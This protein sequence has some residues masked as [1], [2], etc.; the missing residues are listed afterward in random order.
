MPSSELLA[1]IL[2]LLRFDRP[3]SAEIEGCAAP[4]DQAAQRDEYWKPNGSSRPFESARYQ[5]SDRSLYFERREDRVWAL[6]H[7]MGFA[8]MSGQGG[9]NLTINPDSDRRL[10]SQID[11]VAID[12]EVCV[13]VECKSLASRGRRP[14]L[15][16]ELA[17]HS[18]TR[19]ALAKAMQ[20]VEGAKRT[21]GLALWTQNAVL[22]ANDRE[23]AKSNVALLDSDDLDD[24]ETLARHLGPAA[25]HQVPA[26]LTPGCLDTRAS[27]PRTRP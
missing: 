24:H 25:R 12:D 22:S 16:Q 6:L 19:E 4:D 10:T 20:E 1:N 13:A 5:W 7:R 18:L 26:D 21:V 8:S 14:N 11:V 9:A 15:Q 17:K 2:E 3:G 23:R 27:D